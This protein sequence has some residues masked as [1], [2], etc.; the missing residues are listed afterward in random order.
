MNPFKKEVLLVCHNFLT[1][2]II[3]LQDILVDISEALNNETKSS[4]GDKHETS[5]AMLHIEQEK[6]SKQISEASD[7]LSDLS[8]IQFDK[9]VSFIG[10]GSL[11]ETDKG[12]FLIATTIGKLIVAKK[13]VFVISPSSPISRVFNSKTNSNTVIFNNVHYKILNVY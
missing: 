9:E 10:L 13:L 6:I 11:I 12:F 7:L 5:R 4:A 1:E 8:K 2:K 3:S